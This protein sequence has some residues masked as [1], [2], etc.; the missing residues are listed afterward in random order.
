M[1]SA[2]EVKTFIVQMVC[3]FCH[4]GL[5]EEIKGENSEIDLSKQGTKVYRH[6]CSNDSCGKI[7]E[8]KKP[9]PIISYQFIDTITTT[10]T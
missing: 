7:E 4:S 6:K 3:D 2:K 10:G 1:E 9:Y 8:Y 5:M